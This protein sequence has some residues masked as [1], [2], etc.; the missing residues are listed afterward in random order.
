MDKTYIFFVKVS[1]LG[2]AYLYSEQFTYHHGCPLEVVQVTER[3]DFTL[4]TVYTVMDQPKNIYSI[5]YPEVFPA[6]C[7]IITFTIIE[8]HVDG[9]PTIG[10]AYFDNATCSGIKNCT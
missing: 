10:A 8:E 5:S 9:I 7:H 6:Y 1:A 3:K 2:G 4:S